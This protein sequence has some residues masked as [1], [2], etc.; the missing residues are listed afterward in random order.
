[1]GKDAGTK[2]AQV[3]RWDQN[4]SWITCVQ[5]PSL[6]SGSV[7]AL[8][9]AAVT[10]RA[11]KPERW[12]RLWLLLRSLSCVLLVPR[13]AKE[14][15][16]TTHC[17]KL[18]TIHSWGQV[19]LVKI[20]TNGIITQMSPALWAGPRRMLQEAGESAGKPVL[21]WVWTSNQQKSHR[22][23]PKAGGAVKHSSCHP[24]APGHRPTSQLLSFNRAPHTSKGTPM[25]QTSPSEPPARQR[26]RSRLL[27]S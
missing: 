26:H 18:N 20:L 22:A 23:K 10:Q 13:A 12:V 3:T 5:A 11:A 15:V 17:T 21:Q 14:M 25:P 4:W 6:H 16:F 7:T 27:P 19:Q 9:P 8:G 24:P 2:L 1:M